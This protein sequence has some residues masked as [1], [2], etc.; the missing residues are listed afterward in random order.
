MPDTRSNV[1][2]DTRSFIAVARAHEHAAAARAAKLERRVVELEDELQ[3]LRNEVL[4]LNGVFSRQSSSEAQAPYHYTPDAEVTF[5]IFADVRARKIDVASQVTIIVSAFGQ[6][7]YTLRCLRSIA[8]GWSFTVNPT[9][10]VIDDASHDDSIHVL[11]G[12]PGVEI[13]RNGTKLGPLV[14]YNR[15][16]QLATTRYVCFLNSEAEVK[17]GW[18]DTMVQTAQQ[19]PSV[20]AVGSKLIYPDGRLLAAGSIIWSDGSSWNVGRGDD[21]DKSQYNFPRDVDYCSAASLLVRTDRL[22]EIGGFD[23]GYVPGYYAEADLCLELVAR[24]YRVVYEPRSEAVLHEG[25]SSG[26]DISSVVNHDQAGNQAKFAAKW[27]PVLAG[28]FAP[29]ADNVPMAMYGETSKTVLIIDSHVSMHDRDAGSNRLFKIIQILRRM[30]YRVLF[31]PA[32]GWPIE[33]YSTDLARL[34]VEVLYLRPGILD[35]EQLL[36][37]VLRRVDVAWISRPELCERFLSIVREG[38]DAPIIY[39]TVDLHFAREKL[40]AELEGGDDELWR[41]LQDS[42]LAMARAADR[43]VTVT[44]AERG[45]L[46]ELGIDHVSVIPT[47]HDEEKHRHYSYAVRSGLMFIG[48]YGHAPNV[49]AVIWLCRDIMP[50]VWKELPQLT[51]T[52]L[53]NS[54]PEAVTALRSDRVT[55]TG[56]IAHVA[57]YF[58]EAR[59]FVAP[60]RYGAGMKGKVGHALSYGLPMVVTTVATEGFD[61][62]DGENCLIA[63]DAVSFAQAIISLYSDET[64]WNRLSEN[65]TASLRPFGA[66]SVGERLRE[67]FSTLGVGVE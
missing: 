60:L 33:P 28:K 63:D 18:L 55:V 67:L 43:V 56:F 26:T 2:A 29:S 9:I 39:D 32:N 8:L 45:Q 50:L 16:V 21:P 59:I 24:G 58:E 34:G 41:K 19:D 30:H 42:E 1:H 13:V 44:E 40:R 64:L 22:R 54:P 20:G 5:R 31:L 48:G 51:V 49:D 66:E 15:A 12:I 65:G 23:E 37:A 25:T 4:E 6:V 3:H 14:S 36:S 38:T 47:V 62:T 52:L 10:V 53:G 57:P 17:D 35:V 61:L 7:S 46:H 27:V 11:I